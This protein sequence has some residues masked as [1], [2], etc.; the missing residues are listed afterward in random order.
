MPK[1]QGI[2]HFLLISAAERGEEI[3]IAIFARLHGNDMPRAAG[4]IAP[5]AWL[6]FSYTV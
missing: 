6:G 1:Q 4:R 5:D 3:F 2:G